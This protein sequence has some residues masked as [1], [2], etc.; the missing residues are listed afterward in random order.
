MMRND[1]R[2]V[3]LLQRKKNMPRNH[4]DIRIILRVSSRSRP[5]YIVYWGQ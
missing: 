1:S 3:F 4:A 5:R 2:I